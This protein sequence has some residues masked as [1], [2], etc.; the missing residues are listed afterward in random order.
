MS[1]TFKVVLNQMLNLSYKNL[2]IEI[3][4]E[5]SLKVICNSECQEYSVDDVNNS[6]YILGSHTIRIEYV[7]AQDYTANIYIDNSLFGIAT[8]PA[9]CI[10]KCNREAS[11]I[12]SGILWDFNDFK[13]QLID[14]KYALNY[15]FDND[16]RTY[17][18]DKSGINLTGNIVGTVD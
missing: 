18:T 5:H 8:I 15:D 11:I 16:K 6:K 1:G 13:V 3:N 14:N 9:D 4:G 2:S 10:V 12:G 17:A 7:K